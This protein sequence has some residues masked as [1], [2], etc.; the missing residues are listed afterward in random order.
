MPRVRVNRGVKGGWA[1]V[2]PG[3]RTEDVPTCGLRD[4]T[5]VTYPEERA[6]ALKTGQKTLHALVEGELDM[7]VGREECPHRVLYVR[8]GPG[9]FALQDGGS[10]VLRAAAVHLDERGRVWARGPG[11]LTR[12]SGLW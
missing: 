4:A 5:F 10:P 6:V 3:G 12:G 11:P 1:V 9:A 7:S 2:H 8:H